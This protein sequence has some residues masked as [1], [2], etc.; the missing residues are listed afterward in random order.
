MKRGSRFRESNDPA[1]E[2]GIA[3]VFFLPEA[4]GAERVVSRLLDDGVPASRMYQEL[5]RLPHDGTDLH[6]VT[7]WAP[8]LAKRAWSARGGPWAQHPRAVDYPEDGWPRTLDLLRR[9]VHIEI[10][11]DLTPEQVEQIASSLLATAG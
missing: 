9:A 6:V 7:G 11:P 4:G 2:T 8:L 1:G 10:G 3:L 5:S